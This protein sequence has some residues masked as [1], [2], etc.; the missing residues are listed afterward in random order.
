MEH[1]LGATHH[2]VR[3]VFLSCSQCGQQWFADRERHENA[4]ML[5]GAFERVLKSHADAVKIQF[6]VKV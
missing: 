3:K 1:S 6:E 4:D 5:R 2:P